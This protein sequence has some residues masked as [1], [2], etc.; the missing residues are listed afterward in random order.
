MQKLL[1]RL[2]S[3]DRDILRAACDEA[4]RTLPETPE[5]RGALRDAL[6][7]ESLHG[8]FPAA[9]VLFPGES[10]PG[11]GLLPPLLASLELDDGHLRWTAAHLLATLGRMHGEVFPVMLHEASQSPTPRSRRMALYVLRELAPERPET[12]STLLA[13]IHD[14]S[15]EVRRAALSSLAKVH[16]PGPDAVAAAIEVA[17][18]D[19]DPRMRRIAAVLLP[20]LASAHPES[21]PEIRDVLDA[22]CAERD[23]VLARAAG[24]ARNRL[25]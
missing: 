5:L 23:P 10:R 19:E 15:A 17:R 7:R 13:A 14:P 6:G 22:L 1:D 16:E 3:E 18:R 2:A 25:G 20:A 24:I 11:L 21:I 9:W 8:R 4:L 12:H